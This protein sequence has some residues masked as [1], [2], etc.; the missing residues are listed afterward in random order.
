MELVFLSNSHASGN[1]M[2][3]RFQ[4][5]LSIWLWTELFFLPPAARGQ[6]AIMMEGSKNFCLSIFV[7]PTWGDPFFCV[8]YN[9]NIKRQ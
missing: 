6:L 4:W 5:L 2:E 1:K 9:K 8:A 3:E 7:S